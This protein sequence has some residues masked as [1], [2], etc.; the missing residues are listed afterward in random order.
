[1]AKEMIALPSEF[2]LFKPAVLQT[3]IVEDYFETITAPVTGSNQVTFD[4]DIPASPD[5]FSDLSNSY[6][7]VEGQITKSDG[8]NIASTDVVAPAN[9]VLHTLF[10]DIS[11]H[12]CGTQITDTGK[13]YAY[14]AFL[15]TLLSTSSDVQKTRA[16][17]A[18]WELDTEHASVDRVI[19]T[20]SGSTTPNAAFVERKKLFSDGIITI[21]GRPHIDL[22]HQ[23]LDIPPG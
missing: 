6:L 11:V 14:R 20:T 15:E 10:S 13:H 2:D 21:A 18:G 3:A 17:T 22:F 12:I 9:N 7:M 16:R 23:E 1:M 5:L 8:G 19:A 4:I